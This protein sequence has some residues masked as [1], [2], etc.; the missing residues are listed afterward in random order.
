[1]SLKHL[2]AALAACVL[3]ATV[4]TAAEPPLK[5]LIIDGQNN[6]NWK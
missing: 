4:T 3:M 5:A 2:F 6:H 1:M